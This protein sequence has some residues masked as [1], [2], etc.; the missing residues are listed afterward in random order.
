M[1]YSAF[2]SYNHRD[3]A[4]A[5]WLH[6]ALERYRLPRDLI[7]KESPIGVLGRKLPP[8]FQDREEL[9]ASSDLALS[10]RQAL[11]QAASLIVICSSN[12]AKSHWVNEEVK[13]FI[14]QGRR[15]RIQCLIIPEGDEGPRASPRSPAEIFPPALLEG[16][17][18]PLAADATPSADGKRSA[19]LKLIAGVLGVGYDELRRREQARR[20]KRLI[21]ISGASAIGFVA[22][23]GL[24][25]FALV[26]RAEAIRERDVAR[27]KTITAERT[28]DFVKSLFQISDPSEAK[29]AKVTALQVLD[30]GT[31]QIEGALDNEPNVKAE[32]VSTLSEVYLG[33]G[34]Y[35]RADDLIRRSFS[36]RADDRATIARRFAVMADSQSR[37]NNFEAALSAFDKALA[38]MP[39]A[40]RERDSGLFTRILISR[41]EVYALTEQYAN[42]EKD[43][44]TAL[45]IDTKREGRRSPTV[46]RDLEAAG[47]SDNTKG[48]FSRARTYYRDALAIR[49][50]TQGR[51]HPKVADDLNQLGTIA[52]FQHDLAGAAYYMKQTL[53]T[54][55]LVLGPEHPDLATTLNNLARVM[56]EQRKFRQALPLLE[57]SASITLKQQ[58]ETHGDMAF[59]YA[60]RARAQRGLDDP[61]GAAASFKKALRIAQI[62]KQRALPQIMAD[63]ADVKCFQGDIAEGKTL[64]E[65]ATPLMQTDFVDE[66]WRA[67][68][69]TN[70]RGYCAL[71]QGDIRT[72]RALLTRSAPPIRESWK[73]DTLYGALLKER[74]TALDRSGK[75]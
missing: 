56:V 61:D 44:A 3:K 32:I 37:Q 27:Q 33:L 62:R 60:N 35:R 66:P 22:M 6:R 47:F 31:R 41:A 23:S 10:V 5:G 30:R 20:Q 39:P 45:G 24:A 14:A 7:G 48:D 19:L 21:L 43:I 64:L 52:Y 9:A 40:Q 68:W 8:V 34:S 17:A 12:G 4:W 1:R 63:L 53:Q 69:V 70:T 28:T 59:I 50:A 25:A 73:P 55:E 72:A 46:A 74:L 49:L 75:P 57:R 11:E 29:G 65:G 26:S 36:I 13:T 2:I 15:D 51:M 71:R 42:A 54:D 16:G 67:A 58:D 18:E 38:Q